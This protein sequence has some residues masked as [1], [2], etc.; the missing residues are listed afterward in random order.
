MNEY[1]DTLPPIPPAAQTNTRYHA[2]RLLAE[3]LRARPGRWV[4]YPHPVTSPVDLRY[5]IAAGRVAAFGEGYDA[6]IRD[7]QVY[8]RYIP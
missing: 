7:D 6:T 3:E 8:V 4:R 2:N 1:I 5:R